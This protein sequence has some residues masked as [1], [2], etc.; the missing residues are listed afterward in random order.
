MVLADL[1]ADVIKIEPPHTGDDSRA[2]GPFIEEQNGG[3]R[4]YSG[5]YMSINR[6]KRN[7][8]L[9]L[10]TACGKEILREMIKKADI[11]VE[12]FRPTTMEKLGFSFHELQ[13]INPAIIYCSICGFGHDTLPEYS[14]RPAYDMIAQAFS[15]LMSMTGPVGGPPVRVG[16]SIGDILAGYQAVIGIL[17]A[18]RYREKTG[19]GQHVDISMVDGLVS[20][21]ENA[22]VRYTI[23]KEVPAPLGTAH[24]TITPFQAFMAADGKWIVIPIGNDAL[25]QTFC[26]TIRRDD[27][28]SNPEYLTNDLR[29]EHRETLI[30][31]IEREMLKHTAQEWMEILDAHGL[32]YSPINSIDTV[33]AD[34][35]LRHRNMIV[36]IDQP[37]VGTITMTG[38]PFRMDKTPGSIRTPAPFLGENTVEILEQYLGYDRETISSLINERVVFTA[39]CEDE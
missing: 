22:V 10:K 17:A 30:P 20:V 6:N 31:I 27:L 15:G 37:R 28:F 1:G 32:P 3:G 7:I 13:S 14:S 5:Y 38:S 8:C 12:N 25:W 36:D 11:V 23:D 39:D 19:E 2:Y 4:R 16:S 34:P 18:L 33:V 26:T 29:T 21:L 9:D 24:P 35:N